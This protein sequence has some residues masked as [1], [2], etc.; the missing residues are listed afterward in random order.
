MEKKQGGRGS[1]IGVCDCMILLP[2]Y[3]QV[4]GDRCSAFIRV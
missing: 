4:G 2:K 1:I 3:F